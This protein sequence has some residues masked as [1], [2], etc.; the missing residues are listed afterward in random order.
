MLQSEKLADKKLEAPFLIVGSG[1]AGL[2]A[3][4]HAS[5]FGDVI[6]LTKSTLEES[7]S[8]WAQGGIAAAIDPEDSPLYHLEDTLNA[9]RGICNKKAVEILVREGR[10]RV[11]DLINLGMKF[12]STDKGFE[13]GL[14]GGHTKRRVLHSGGNSTGKEIVEFLISS[15][16]KLKGIMILENTAVEKL[17]SDG[18]RCFGALAFRETPLNR[19]PILSGATILAT[20][21]AAALYSRTTNPPGA[22]GEGISLAYRSGAEI[23]DIEFVQFHPT[24]LYAKNGGS[25]LISEAVRGEGAHLLNKDGERF[26]L[27]YHELGELAPRDIVSKAIFNEIKT[28]GQNYVFLSLKHL[29]KVFVRKRFANI[30]NMCSK[31]GIDISNDLIPVA[32]AA[33]YTIGGVKTGLMGETNIEGLFA[34]GEVA[35]TGV[36]GANRLASNSLLECIV[37]AKR[38]V[39]A[40]RNNGASIKNIDHESIKKYNQSFPGQQGSQNEVFSKIKNIVSDLM[41]ENVGIIRSDEGLRNSITELEKIS[42]STNEL[43]GYYKQRIQDILELCKLTANAA[44]LRK[45]SRGAHIR[46]DF[47]DEDPQFRAHIVWKRGFEPSI[48]KCN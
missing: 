8:Y 36:H 10:E 27:R 25:F 16:K 22:T 1:L 23:T 34:C 42:R 30:H 7:N 26:M 12:D 47:P 37:F 24:T 18:K 19:M 2:Y 32:P 6:L 4:L 46:E 15:V 17:I 29:D 14:E 43:S 44:L 41:N 11:L 45:E 40:A 5:N 31:S 21:G 33:H 9:G 13:L 28:S 3:A 39:D 20:G 38:A 48:I 35:C